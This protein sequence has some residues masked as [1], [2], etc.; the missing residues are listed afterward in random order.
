MFDEQTAHAAQGA[1]ET[2]SKVK[3]GS[4]KFSGI[5]INH[6]RIT[7]FDVW[8]GIPVDWERGWNRNCLRA[9]CTKRKLELTAWKRGEFLK[10]TIR[11]ILTFFWC[12]L[13]L[14]ATKDRQPT[15]CEWRLNNNHRVFCKRLSDEHQANDF[16]IMLPCG[17][18][19]QCCIGDASNRKFLGLFNCHGSYMEKEFFL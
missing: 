2:H 11:L 15:Q 14:M 5:Y 8:R 19:M 17:S 12:N 18:A 6:K 13:P 9:D 1:S 16:L 7:S 10:L 3:S 4:G